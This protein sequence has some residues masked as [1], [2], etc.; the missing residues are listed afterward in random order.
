MKIAYNAYCLFLLLLLII[1]YFLNFC[2]PFFDATIF[3]WIQ[4]YIYILN[5]II[6]I[7][8]VIKS[9]RK[10]K[11]ETMIDS[12]TVSKFSCMADCGSIDWKILTSSK[13]LVFT[14]FFSDR[15]K[16]FT[17][18]A[19][20]SIELLRLRCIPIVL[21]RK[22]YLFHFPPKCLPASSQWKQVRLT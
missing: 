12:Q 8:A 22:L 15:I 10:S 19:E 20:L 17:N 5:T 3:W 11:Q 16:N 18:T 1:V 6:I 2:I 13:S 4:M 7:I 9:L 21:L 14:D